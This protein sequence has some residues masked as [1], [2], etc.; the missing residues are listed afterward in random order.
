VGVEKGRTG[1]MAGTH[2]SRKSRRTLML[3]HMSC[4]LCRHDRTP[5]QRTGRS[6]RSKFGLTAV[7]DESVMISKFGRLQ[8]ETLHARY[9]KVIRR[10]PLNRREERVHARTHLALQNIVI[11]S[12]N[13]VD[14][15]S[16]REDENSSVDRPDAMRRSKIRSRR[17]SKDGWEKD[18]YAPA[19]KINT[20]GLILQ[21]Q[22]SG[23]NH[24][25][26]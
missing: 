5:G 13:D 15:T 4:K 2:H 21:G 8:V 19:P 17:A 24:C 6:P 20:V 23:R 7:K 10:R 18:T 3:L 12:G 14:S 16:L 25:G 26:I 1:V 11:R 22:G 9:E